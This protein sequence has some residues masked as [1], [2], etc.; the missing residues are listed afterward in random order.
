MPLSSTLPVKPSVTTTSTRSVSTS[1]PSTLPT[2]F[3]SLSWASSSW[4]VFTSVLPFMD[5]SP[6][7]ISP[8]LG[9]ATS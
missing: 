3:T 6:M 2:K 9:L 7:D 5:S 1:R 8:T 4:V